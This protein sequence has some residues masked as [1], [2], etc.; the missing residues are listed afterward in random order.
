M[1]EDRLVY[2]TDKSLIC[3]TCGKLPCKCP[4]KKAALRP[5]V[6]GK[7]TGPLRIRLEKSG[8]GGKSVTVVF[9]LP[10]N[11]AC[12]QDMIKQLK[13]HCGSGG[14]LKEGRMEIQGD[15]RQKVKDFLEKAGFKVV[16]A[17]GGDMRG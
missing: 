15:H 9:D 17:G 7:H 4:P 1:S 5:G 10:G 6:T 14:T 11:T 2:S 16:L 12:F 13:S 8:R 3:K